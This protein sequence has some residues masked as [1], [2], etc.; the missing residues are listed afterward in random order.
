MADFLN[1]YSMAISVIIFIA[2]YVVMLTFQRIRAYAAL[3]AGAVFVIIGLIAKSNNY[4]TPL[5]A[6]G[7]INWNV[8]MM[9]AGTMGTVA[10][11]IESNM[12][13]RL[14]DLI[15]RKVPNAK[16]TIV[17]LSVFAGIVSAFVDNV[18]TVLMIAPVGLAIAKKLK[19]SPIPVLIAISVSSNL[20]GAATLV[21]DT[22]S[23]LLAGEA[24]MNFLDFM[25]MN[26]KPGI[27]WAVQ[28]GTLCTVPVLLILFRKSNAPVE[29]GELSPVND[30]VPTY[31]LCANILL[32]I[33]A[34][35][36][37]NLP[38]FLDEYKNGII[39]LAICII[40]LVYATVKKRNTSLTT[41]MLKEIDIITLLL[42]AGLFVVIKSIEKAGVIDFVAQR[43]ALVGNK[44]GVF[45]LYTIIVWASV[46][47]SAFIDNIPYVATML[48]V[49]TALSAKM[50][51]AGAN[52]VLYYGLL[53]GA[54]LG[55]NITP[56][57]ASANIAAIGIL[58]KEGYIVKNS[59]FFKI[60]IP[61][62]L[63]A[64]VAGYAYI[65]AFWHP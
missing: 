10:L 44:F 3:T 59:D 40:S 50:D 12:P 2:M 27:C 63:C 42:L 16:W 48:P 14:S 31:L 56:V 47:F 7:G 43:F 32:L 45:A 37:P 21:G 58:S 25:W 29:K 9:L 35:F 49:I 55:G 15:L 41:R 62:T 60:G 5:E 28:L 26:G 8:I 34:S 64:V 61:F 57:G 23:I 18:A 17:I 36:I 1:E 39:C 22:T 54:T 53:I 38:P 20:Q 4:L 33:V 24:D 46:F 6:L 51:V 30:Y 13:S 19:I 11:F 52:F 65:W